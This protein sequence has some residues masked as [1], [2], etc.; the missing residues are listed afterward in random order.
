MRA[1]RSSIA[2]GVAALTCWAWLASQMSRR[3]RLRTRTAL[4]TGTTSWPNASIAAFTASARRA[5]ASASGT[6]GTL[7]RRRIG[8]RRELRDRAGGRIHRGDGRDVLAALGRQAL[9]VTGHHGVA[10]AG[11]ADGA[12]GHPHHVVADDR[13]RVG[14]G[15]RPRGHLIHA[16]HR[17]SGRGR[18][19]R[20]HHR[21]G[22]QTAGS[23]ACKNPTAAA[24]LEDHDDL[25]Y[26]A[27]TMSA[28]ARAKDGS[29]AAT[30]SRSGSP[31]P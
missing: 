4:W 24:K 23:G 2:A 19:E 21:A 10:L 6:V 12:V 11:D 25:V 17:L 29:V 27:I 22:E 7:A 30:R 16:V 8:A 31:R 1:S 9:P 14:R 5:G 26:L 18:P 13:P 3:S 28:S 15:Q 20:N